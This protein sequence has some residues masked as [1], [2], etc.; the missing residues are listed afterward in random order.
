MLRRRKFFCLSGRRGTDL[1]LSVSLRLTA[2]PKGGAKDNCAVAA[3][4]PEEALEPTPD[5][6]KIQLEAIAVPD[7]KN[8]T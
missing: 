8:F 6:S 3:G 1:A 5:M 7:V 4:R 2:P